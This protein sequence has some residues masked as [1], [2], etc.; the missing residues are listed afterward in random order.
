ML[1]VSNPWKRGGGLG[2][3]TT[4]NR[5]LTEKESANPVSPPGIISTMP[6]VGIG[7]VLSQGNPEPVGVVTFGPREQCDTPRAAKWLKC[8]VEMSG[9]ALLKHPPR[10]LYF[11]GSL[12]TP[13]PGFWSFGEAHLRV[14]TAARYQPNRS[15]VRSF[16]QVC[17]FAGPS[18]P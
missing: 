14:H 15:H 5:W 4:L 12:P 18:E 8:R 16:R 10:R 3:A 6:A 2:G 11:T 17:R 9:T 1:G 7:G 13:I